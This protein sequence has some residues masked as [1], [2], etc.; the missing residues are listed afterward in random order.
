[1][2][3]KVDVNHLVALG[4]GG[5]AS[6]ASLVYWI[7]KTSFKRQGDIT[8]RYFGHLEKRDHDQQEA[9]KV[10]GESMERVARHLDEQSAILKDLHGRTCR[11]L[12]GGKE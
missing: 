4:M 12:A 3:D 7:V 6:F 2:V 8:D 1:M 9:I 10:F 5:L 11:Y